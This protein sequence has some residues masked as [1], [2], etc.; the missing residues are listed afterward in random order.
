MIYIESNSGGSSGGHLALRTG[1]FVF[2]FQQYP[3]GF[4]RLKRDRWKHFRFVYNDIEN[5]SIFLAQTPVTEQQYRLIN[6]HFARFILAQDRNFQNLAI[7]ERDF[8]FRKSPEKES[9]FLEIE[10]AGLFQRC[11]GAVSSPSTAMVDLRDEVFRR[12]GKGFLEKEKVRLEGQIKRLALDRPAA[13]VL[14]RDRMDFVPIVRTPLQELSELLEL[15]AAFDVLEKA[16]PVREDVLMEI[17]G[18]SPCFRCVLRSFKGK[19]ESSVIALFSSNRPD[20]GRVLLLQMARFQAVSR[21]IARGHLF[22][23]DPFHEEC[24]RVS[25][26]VFMEDRDAMEGLLADMKGRLLGMEKRMCAAGIVDEPSYNALENLAARCRELQKGLQNREYVRI[27]DEIEIP[28]RKGTIELSET[29]WKQGRKQKSLEESRKHYNK[30]RQRLESLY[31]YDLITSNC[32]T[33]LTDEV[34]AS[35]P[36]GHLKDVLEADFSVAKAA[37]FVPFRFFDYWVSWAGAE[38]VIFL[39]SFRRRKLAGLYRKGCRLKVYLRE[40]NTLTSS[41]YSPNPADTSF[42]VF[43]DDI[44]FARPL[45]GAA[46]IAWG[47]FTAAAGLVTAPFDHARRIRQGLWGVIYSLPEVV[48]SNIRKGSFSRVKE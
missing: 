20:R 6:R 8:R 34:R 4:F 46:N 12:F 47:L 28:C 36:Q 39:P 26:D 13:H 33:R 32:V 40:F 25:P 43:T 5:R 19:L 21:S 14:P 22:V 2:H 45:F 37:N 17:E 16:E 30:Y 23:L 15:K 38:R 7:L 35:L 44:F 10:A 11:K 41:I 31:Q 18:I 48:F 42:L 9:P 29:V 24:P 1:D 3:D 27:S